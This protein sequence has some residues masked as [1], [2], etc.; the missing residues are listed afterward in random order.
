MCI[1][2]SYAERVELPNNLKQM[3][4]PVAMMVPDTA[5]IAEVL[6]FINGFTTSSIL[7]TKLTKFYELSE[8]LHSKE[9]CTCMTVDVTMQYKL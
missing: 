6:L 2:C 5:M 1:L 3:F 9:V 4:R 8:A 7:A